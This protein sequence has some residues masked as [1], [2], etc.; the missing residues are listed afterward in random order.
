MTP[1]PIPKELADLV[2]HCV[3]VERL[4]VPEIA[5]RAGTTPGKMFRV[6]RKL[7]LKTTIRLHMTEDEKNQLRKLVEVDK[8]QHYK[9]AE[10]MGW[11][12][13]QTSARIKRLGLK[14]QRTGPRSGPG[15]P[16][17]KGGRVVDKHGYI[18]VYA[19]GHHLSRQTTKHGK[20]SRVYAPEHRLVMEKKLGRPLLPTEVVDH[21]N[22]VVDDNRPENLRVF[23][24][25]G[26]HLHETLIGKCPKWSKEGKARILAAVRSRGGN[27]R[28]DI[29]INGSQST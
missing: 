16:D 6:L 10:L 26:E 12:K 20:K 1:R 27:T 22:G 11:T 14:T 2:T 18:L 21:I 7:G 5:A 24:S 8:L 15:H 19:P 17:W 9:I 25:N 4:T 23:A 28:P 13:K 3:H 29:E